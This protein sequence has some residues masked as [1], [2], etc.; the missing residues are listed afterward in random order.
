MTM[1]FAHKRA[2]EHT[3]ESLAGSTSAYALLDGTGRVRWVNKAF[4]ELVGPA[5]TRFPGASLDELSKAFP[6]P[7]R[8]KPEGE[9]YWF[10][11]NGRAI[12]LSRTEGRRK[13]GP[14][15]AMELWLAREAS[16]PSD[17]NADAA[18]GLDR[19]GRQL[20]ALRM[21]LDQAP[22]GLWLHN[23][24]GKIEFMNRTLREA[25]GISEERLRQADHYLE[26]IDPEYVTAWLDSDTKAL[27]SDQPCVSEE[28]LP[29]TDGQVH[30][31]R[32]VK[33]VQRDAQGEP[34][35]LIGLSL[36]ITEERRQA[37]SLGLWSLVADT[38]REAIA[39]TDAEQRIIAVNA[40]FKA[41]YGDTGETLVGQ[42]PG[43]F[44]S[45][46][47]D[48]EYYRNIWQA[49]ETKG[50][51]QGELLDRR[52]NGEI[53]T[54]W[55]SI[56]AQRDE[57]GVVSHYIATSTDVSTLKKAQSR[58]NHLAYHDPLTNLPN[59][60]LF[61]DRVKHALENAQRKGER[62]AL[63]YFD[64]DNF[65]HINES[66]G[67]PAGDQL[68][69]DVTKRLKA[70]A[71]PGDT[72]A[73]LGGD[74]FILLCEA[75]GDAT[76][77]TQIADKLSASFVD[78]FVINELPCHIDTSMGISVYP[79]DADDVT[80]LIRDA[81]AAMYRA[82]GSGK[83]RYQFYS[84]DLTDLAYQRL[85]LENDLRQAIQNGDLEVYFQPQIHLPSES[86]LG[87][88]A[89]IRWH[90]PRQGPI[91]PDRF[92]P[93]AESSRLIVQ[94][95]EWVMV[96]SCQTL[97]DLRLLGHP[98]K[99][100]AVNVSAVQLRDPLFAV[101]VRT[102][103][104]ETECEPQWLE[105][106]VTESLLMDNREDATQMLNELRDLGVCVAIDDF[107]TGYS[108]LAQL[109]RLPVDRLKIDKAFVTDIPDNLD[110]LAITRAIIAMA[111][112][113]RLEVI[114][115][116]VEK[117]EQADCLLDEGCLEAQ[118]Y[119]YGRPMPLAKLKEHLGLARGVPLEQSVAPS[120]PPQSSSP[121]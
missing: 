38:V 17:P 42:K 74:E 26:L 52:A 22:I 113:L 80:E 61:E 95:G 46:M 76:E 94:I 53:I 78:P 11:F 67:H 51:W 34:S 6:L 106:E 54:L 117:R 29:F 68:L 44:K 60:L 65:K 1:V 87:L 84:R 71:R 92:I 119:M 73:R 79:D 70:A 57:K 77:I 103:L 25:L 120:P 18:S 10:G 69:R 55:Q 101:K 49:I 86:L 8:D 24:R 88:E 64:L 75:V 116:G 108:S 4:S 23:G 50:H 41:L 83:G 13:P 114:A 35:A 9:D 30:D 112:S 102:I 47:H 111:A 58:L 21:V 81:D 63:L 110:D 33:V 31:L 72:L 28:R 48:A 12:R 14:A 20:D 85:T 16:P 109:K 2:E 59:R 19:A 97:R 43:L 90:H 105:I 100:V 91:S 104:E 56:I 98:I 27:A 3:P 36:D 5:A 115:E 40:G 15:Q 93:V 121:E 32:I 107:G 45:D 99:R 118:G 96:Q 66:F 89:L 62:M 37:E 7:G 82:K 39:I